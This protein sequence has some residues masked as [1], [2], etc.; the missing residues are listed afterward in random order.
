MANPHKW[1][2]RAF[3]L[4][5]VTAEHKASNFSWKERVRTEVTWEGFLVLNLYLLLSCEGHKG[6]CTLA[7]PSGV[8]RLPEVGRNTS[9]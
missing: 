9:F 4:C 5:L 7:M 3:L 2:R 8:R 6:A 1:V